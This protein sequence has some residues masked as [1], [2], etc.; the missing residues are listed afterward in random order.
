M[1]GFCVIKGKKTT[2]SAT[3]LISHELGKAKLLAE[4]IKSTSFHLELP[5]N[6]TLMVEPDGKCCLCE[7]E[8]P[9]HF[10]APLPVFG[11]T[12]CWLILFRF[13]FLLFTLDGFM[14]V[15]HLSVPGKMSFNR[16]NYTYQEM[17]H[18][19]SFTEVVEQI[20]LELASQSDEPIAVEDDNVPANH[21]EGKDDVFD[22]ISSDDRFT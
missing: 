2:H 7:C 22:P 19:T 1:F 20:S 5:P 13:L 11:Y 4:K 16:R 15:Q 12:I 21:L 8:L 6:E 18:L 14:M 10:S 9:I 17:V 3:N